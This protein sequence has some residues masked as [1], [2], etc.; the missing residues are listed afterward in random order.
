MNASERVEFAKSLKDGDCIYIAYVSGSSFLSVIKKAEVDEHCIQ[1]YGYVATLIESY[2][3][4]TIDTLNYNTKFI[5]R[6]NTNKYFERLSFMR[7]ATVR[8]VEHLK[9]LIKNDESKFS[10]SNVFKSL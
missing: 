9:A 3:D 6:N 10:E 2:Y 8:E 1:L 7:K 5:I 4:D